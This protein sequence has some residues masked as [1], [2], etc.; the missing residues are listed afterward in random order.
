MNLHDACRFCLNKSSANSS[1]LFFHVDESLQKK[2]EDIT[3]M[4]LRMNSD[5]LPTTAC[6]TCITELEEHHNYR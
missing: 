6:S 4:E 3:E 5:E 2:F 1:E